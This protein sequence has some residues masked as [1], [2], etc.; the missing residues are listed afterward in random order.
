MRRCWNSLLQ[1]RASPAA[2]TGFAIAALLAA[3][4]IAR[5]VGGEPDV[6]I[7][8]NTLADGSVEFVLEQRSEQQAEA[9]DGWTAVGR[10][11]A[12]DQTPAPAE[13]IVETRVVELSSDLAGI[14]PPGEEEGGEADPDA[15]VSEQNTE[16]VQQAQQEQSTEEAQTAT[17]MIEPVSP[18]DTP[19]AAVAAHPDALYFTASEGRWSEGRI[20][21]GCYRFALRISGDPA[22]Y[23]WSPQLPITLTYG[24][25]NLDHFP[26]LN[27]VIA[28][29]ATDYRGIGPRVCFREDGKLG[30]YI[31]RPSGFSDDVFRWSV[32]LTPLG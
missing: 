25:E 12:A 2:L 19:S 4:M 31:Y 27:G 18:A 32:R 21:A 29:G 14:M 17:A 13:E 10:W 24:H 22:N 28:P 23:E 16:G 7:T 30:V 26:R 11:R 8:A 20:G 6:R 15:A 1:L 3:T 9:E 5:G